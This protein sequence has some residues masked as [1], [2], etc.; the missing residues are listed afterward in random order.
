MHPDRVNAELHASGFDAIQS[1]DLEWVS[2]EGGEEGAEGESQRGKGR[3]KAAKR[4]KMRR[5]VSMALLDKE[6]E[7]TKAELQAELMRV[8]EKKLKGE[9]EPKRTPESVQE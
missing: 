3:E 5:A 2:N 8:R 9:D 7:E 6:T 1:G 4:L